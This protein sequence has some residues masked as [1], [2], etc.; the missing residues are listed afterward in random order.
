MNCRFGGEFRYDKMRFRAGGFFNSDPFRTPQNGVS[1]DISGLTGG[2]G[3]RE[4]RYYVDLA[5]VLS[6]GSQS[7]RPYRI[8]TADSPL[9]KS[10][11]QSWL[12]QV[13]LGLPL[14]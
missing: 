8:P 12:V 2:F 10:Q 1:R 6:N 4:S 11:N 9:V 13:T 7:Y 5:V 14:Q 3:Y